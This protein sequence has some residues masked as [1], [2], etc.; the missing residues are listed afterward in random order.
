MN[1]VLKLRYLLEL[2]FLIFNAFCCL[3]FVLGNGHQRHVAD[4]FPKKSKDL[5]F[6]IERNPESFKY[7][8]IVFL[9]AGNI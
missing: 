5:G 1:V 9:H 4:A 6:W 8:S 7:G 2:P 3:R